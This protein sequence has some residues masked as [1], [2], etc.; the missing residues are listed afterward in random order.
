MEIPVESLFR[1]GTK[2]LVFKFTKVLKEGTLGYLHY[3]E[4]SQKTAVQTVGCCQDYF[5]CPH[6]EMGLPRKKRLVLLNY[7]T[8]EYSYRFNSPSVTRNFSF[9]GLFS[10]AYKHPYEYKAFRYLPFIPVHYVKNYSAM[11]LEGQ[12]ILIREGLA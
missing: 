6:C 12:N 4:F 11:L 9:I 5:L 3:H 10:S 1:M 2:E 8:K 7:Q